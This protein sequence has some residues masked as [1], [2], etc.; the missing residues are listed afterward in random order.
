MLRSPAVNKKSA[1][2]LLLEVLVSITVIAVGLVYIVRSFS[3]SSRAIETA[4][5]YLKSVSFLEEKL[6]DLE[7]RKGVE[8]GRETG[9]FESDENYSWKTEIE[10]AKEIPINKV[11]IEVEWAGTIRKQRVSL[12]TC[13]W[14]Y[15]EE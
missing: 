13:M 5:H 4:A 10:E 2:F 14:N 9:R 12:E 15:E 11:G 6:W 7:A 3:S 8:R 1:G